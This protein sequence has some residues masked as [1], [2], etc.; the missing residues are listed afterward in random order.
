MGL[1]CST[2]REPM[3]RL[4]DDG[5]RVTLDLH[6]VTVDRALDIAL[7]T[8]I[9]AARR[10]RSTLRVVHGASSCE[11]GAEQTI[12]SELRDAVE[13]GEFSRH[14]TTHVYDDGAILLG[15]APAPRPV[16]GRI[17]LADVW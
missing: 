1:P 10:G 7:A 13:A 6:G 4:E 5:Q 12:R 8:A 17:H 15:L 11:R 9:E 3:P 16:P 2:A 14:V